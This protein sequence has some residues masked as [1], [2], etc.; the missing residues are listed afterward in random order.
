[1]TDSGRPSTWPRSKRL[2]WSMERPGCGAKPW[3][4]GSGSMAAASAEPPPNARETTTANH[5]QGRRGLGAFTPDAQPGAPLVFRT[6]I[7]KDSSQ[8]RRQGDGPAAAQSRGERRTANH[9]QGRRGL[10]AFTP[11]AQPGAPPEFPN[12][13]RQALTAMA[14]PR[15][16]PLSGLRLRFP[17]VGHSFPAWAGR[18]SP[19]SNTSASSLINPLPFSSTPLPPLGL[20]RMQQHVTAFRRQVDADRIRRLRSLAPSI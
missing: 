17:E 12:V 14:P 4:T 20:R 3:R 9:A 6:F 15:R 1:M 5:A 16:R 8:W 11:D 13:H 18:I 10:G 19:L 2:A 7:G